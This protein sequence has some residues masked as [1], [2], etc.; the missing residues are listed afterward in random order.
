MKKYIVY[1]VDFTQDPPLQ[2]KLRSSSWFSNAFFT[3]A[4]FAVNNS[5][6]EDFTIKKSLNAEMAWSD[7]ET[8]NKMHHLVIIKKKTKKSKES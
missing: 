7:K 4:N 3:A 8:F 6:Q 5:L 1:L 2:R